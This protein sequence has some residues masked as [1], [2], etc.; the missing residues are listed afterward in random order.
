MRS[1]HVPQSR[2]QQLP[3]PYCP[4]LWLTRL[5]LVSHSRDQCDGGYFSWETFE[6]VF[7]DFSKGVGDRLSLGSQGSLAG[8]GW[9]GPRGPWNLVSIAM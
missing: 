5:L 7:D 4:S 2:F 9:Q 6:P 3:D 1:P 8:R